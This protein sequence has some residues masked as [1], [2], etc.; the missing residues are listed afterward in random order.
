MFRVFLLQVVYSLLGPDSNDAQGGQYL[1]SVGMLLVS[2]L[3]G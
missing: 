2:T 1:P 3:G